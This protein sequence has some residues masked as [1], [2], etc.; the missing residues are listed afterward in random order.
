[1][2]FSQALSGLNGAAKNLDVIGNNI[3][4]SATVGFKASKTQFADIYATSKV[5]IGTKVAG[6]IQN[7]N[8]GNMETTD[9]N[10]DI[11]ISGDGFLTF[12][13]G[14]QT[15][16]SR[17]GQLTLTPDGFLTNAQ[18]ARLIG[19]TGVMQLP[20]G[21]MQASET[22][23]MNQTLNLDSREPVIAI[24]FNST[25]PNSYNFSNTI[26]TFDSLGN[27]QKV[28]LYYVKSGV[29]TWDVHAGMNGAM[30]ASPVQ[31]LSFTSNGTLNAYAPTNFAFPLANGANNMTVTLDMTG[32][33][34]FGND[35]YVEN[36]TQNGYTSGGLVGITIEKNGDIVGNYANEQKRVLDTIQMATFRNNEGLKPLG[37]NVWAETTA[38]G[39]P[40]VGS[41]GVGRFGDIESGVVEASNVNMTSELVNMIIAQRAF[42]ANAQTIKTQ[43]EILQQ[44]VNL[45]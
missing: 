45:R 34:Q 25:D 42:Q 32:S 40:L 5:G 3:A 19:Q 21:G 44:A 9:R 29:N 23:S 41:A 27:L 20:A 18:G 6:V 8:S 12:N 39:Q 13:Q 36:Q 35:F 26:S 22:T 43:D 2:G 10:L 17:N 37:D 4:N 30:S 1:M 14:G 31:N 33:T 38:S 24:P 28:N 16:Y 7:F 15:V 11:A